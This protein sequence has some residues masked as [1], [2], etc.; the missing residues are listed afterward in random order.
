MLVEPLL[1]AAEE[2]REE[3]RFVLVDALC[4]VPCEYLPPERLPEL[5][6]WL[7]GMLGNGSQELDIIALHELLRLQR[8]CRLCAALG[9]IAPAPLAAREALQSEL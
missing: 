3:D 9:R 8:G 5:T 7:T 4:H 6:D 1:R 2:A